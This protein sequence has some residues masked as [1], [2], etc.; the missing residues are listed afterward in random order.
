MYDDGTLKRS[1]KFDSTF[2]LIASNFR[3]YLN[4]SCYDLLS[5]SASENSDWPSKFEHRAINSVMSLCMYVTFS[6][7]IT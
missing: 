2:E 4:S 7:R 1:M 6:V 5:E 3:E